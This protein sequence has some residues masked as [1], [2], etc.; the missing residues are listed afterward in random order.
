MIHFLA[1]L[2]VGH[3]IEFELLRD[4]P[5]S[6]QFT[7][8]TSNGP[9]TNVFWKKDDRDLTL[10]HST[11]KDLQD[12]VTATYRSELVVNENAPGTYGCFATNRNIQPCNSDF[13]Q[14][15]LVLSAIQVHGTY[16]RR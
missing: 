10:N 2:L 12:R 8:T 3:K 9:A 16:V 6:F 1:G 11:H 13:N 7:C 4:H 5:I 15:A 14:A